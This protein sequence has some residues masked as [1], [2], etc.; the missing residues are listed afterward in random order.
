MDQHLIVFRAVADKRSFSQAAKALHISQP[1]IS[2]Q[3][4]SLEE[5]LST[6]LFDRNNKRV[7]LTQAGKTFYKYAT[8]IMELYEQAH[9]DISELT[10]MVKGKIEIGAS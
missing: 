8:Q 6:R 5:Q 9:K 2:L 3:I 1:A 7:I 10:G 4:Q